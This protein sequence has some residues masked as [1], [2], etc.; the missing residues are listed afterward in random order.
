MC[1][2]AGIWNRDGR[3]IE[4][5]AIE[6]MNAV[7]RHRGPDGEGVWQRQGL[8]LGHRR[9]AIVDSG[10]GGKQPMQ[11]RD[12]SLC[13]TFN[14]EIHNF[15]EL[16]RELTALGADFTTSSDTE[17]LLHGYRR[18]GL[19]LFPR[20]NGM[21]ALAIW[22][23]RTRELVLSRDRFGIKP[24][25]VA[26]DGATLAF[27][28]EIKALLAFR[29]RWARPNRSQIVSFL[30]GASPSGGVETFFRDVRAVEPATCEIVGTETHRHRRY[31]SLPEAE[32]VP[33]DDAPRALRELLD[34]AVR[35]RLRS[36]VPVGACLSGGLDSSS[37]VRLAHRHRQDQQDLHCFSIRLDDPQCDESAFA[38]RAVDGLEGVRMHWVEPTADGL[39]DIADQV[40]WHHDGPTPSRGRALQWSLFRAAGRHVK[41]VLD[42]QG[43]DELLAGYGRF[44][45]ARALDRARRALGPGTARDLAD[46]G[47]AAR[48]LLSSRLR[49]TLLSALARRA[50][51]PIA[52]SASL[53]RRDALR[54]VQPL[55]MNSFRDSFLHRD[56]PSPDGTLLGGALW[57]EFERSGLPELL[58]AEDALGMAASVEARPPFLDHRVVEFCFAQPADAKIDA[59]GWSKSLLR[60]ALEG[61]LPE[62]IRRRRD[63]K[64]FSFPLDRW[65]RAPANEARILDLL[66]DPEARTRELLQPATME[67]FLGG[68][69]RRGLSGY[70]LEIL[71]RCLCL[72]LWWRRFFDARELSGAGA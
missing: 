55:D 59:D 58:H 72:E 57:G 6:R 23:E 42:G 38:Q 7:Q 26:E 43:A 71:W 5:G 39:V 4:A 49:P 33:A 20:I 69:R 70:G 37:V 40:V 13:V 35:L 48:S 44:R 22:D 31:W 2:I 66:L 18:W 21:W 41:V 27:A 62:A 8:V 52:P 30:A 56:A 10:E 29:P 9:L 63:K 1:G 16:R 34:D 24:L 60:Q 61:V 54:A 64:G 25:H 17:I 14:G 12:G 53:I 46:A 19:D 51:R 11:S 68:W 67:R 15:V 65:M 32:A 45:C 36:D 47:R 50:G 3:P 28:S